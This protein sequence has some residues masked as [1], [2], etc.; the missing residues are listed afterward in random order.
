MEFNFDHIVNA[1]ERQI[2]SKSFHIELNSINKIET[3]KNKDWGHG[4]AYILPRFPHRHR[5]PSCRRFSLH[6]VIILQMST[7][8][9]Q[10]KKTRHRRQDRVSF[11]Q[12]DELECKNTYPLRNMINLYGYQ[13]FLGASCRKIIQA[14]KEKWIEERG[15]RTWDLDEIG[16]LLGAA[17]AAGRS[18]FF[19]E[20]VAAAGRASNR[21]L[22]S[23]PVE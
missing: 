3:L 14:V 1:Y 16:V 23:P 10:I 4:R 15:I 21:G 19:G 13:V 7:A 2:R 17:A 8:F 18:P 5:I 11:H 12:N 22:F 20:H 6:W 9:S